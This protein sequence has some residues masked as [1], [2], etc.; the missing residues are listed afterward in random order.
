MTRLKRHLI[1]LVL[2]L[3]IVFCIGMAVYYYPPLR[4]AVGNEYGNHYLS[5]LDRS[6]QS[7]TQQCELLMNG[8]AGYQFADNHGGVIIANML[9]N[10]TPGCPAKVRA[11]LSES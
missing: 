7:V 11:A 4:S 3:V 9:I 1:K 8:R 6:K 2:L 10:K 5:Q